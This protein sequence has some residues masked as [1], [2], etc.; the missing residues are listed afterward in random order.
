MSFASGRVGQAF[1]FDG[2][3][4]VEVPDAPSLRLV[5]EL[6]IEFWVRRERLD[7]PHYII[8]KGG[9]WTRGVQNYAV[10]LHTGAYNNCLHFLFGGG[11]RG[12][13]SVAGGSSGFPTDRSARR[14]PG[15]S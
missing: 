6:T 12:G 3:S 14:D 7:E 13:G 11:W 8:E 2:S 4:Y 9:D 5:N 1:A 15:Q 10:A